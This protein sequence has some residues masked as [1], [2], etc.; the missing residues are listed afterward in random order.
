MMHF[1]KFTFYLFYDKALNGTYSISP[2]HNKILLIKMWKGFKK[3][4]EVSCPCSANKPFKHYDSSN[5][6]LLS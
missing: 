4:I 1:D 2:P 3:K 6:F 5:K